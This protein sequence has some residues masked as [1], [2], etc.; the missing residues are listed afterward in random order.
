MLPW[1]LLGTGALRTAAR[2]IL[3]DPSFGGRAGELAAWSRANNGGARGAHLVE[4]LSE[5]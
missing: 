3:R 5:Q 4:D 1:R 2:R